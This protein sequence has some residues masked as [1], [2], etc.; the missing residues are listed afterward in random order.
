MNNEE[1]KFIL[2]GYRPGGA[3][4]G[5]ATFCAALGQ[6]KEDP[7]LGDWFARQQA[8]DATISAKLAQIAPPADLRAAILAGGKM[9]ATVRPMGRWWK[10]PVWLAAAAGI[11]I[12]LAAGA[13]LCL[14]RVRALPEFALT[15]AKLSA[16]HGGHGHENNALQAVLNDPATRLGQ[17]LPIQF[18]NLL[19]TG[20][21]SLNCQGHVV[22]ELCFKRNG[23]WFHA[24]F[25]RKSDFSQLAWGATP[26]ITDHGGISMA[27][28]ADDEHVILVVSK[29]G[30]KSL[31]ALL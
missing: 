24:Y 29:T 18:A 12:L 30:R 15:D 31:E 3:D 20:C 16:T 25:A 21:R 17:K 8:F 22:L 27:T 11:A 2:H 1:A 13:A 4:A 7:A 10:R 26:S 6:A 14:N 28:W 5:D 9:T 23:V 19:E